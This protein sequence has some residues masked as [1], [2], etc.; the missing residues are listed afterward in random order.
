[1][2][3]VDKMDAVLLKLYDKS[4]EA[5][6]MAKLETWLSN[7]SIHKGEIE[8]ITL[9]LYR[10]EYMYSCDKSGDRNAEYHDEDMFLLSCEGKLFW[11]NEKGFRFYFA[12]LATEKAAREANELR[13]ALWTKR[14]TVAT[15]L[16]ATVIVGW[17]V[18][19]FGI[20]RGWEY[21]EYSVPIII[22]LSILCTLLLSLL[23]KKKKPKTT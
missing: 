11:E 21:R 12:K 8:D 13:L 19:K 5:P 23:L 2:E 7:E 17:D 4:G 15:Y 18:A 3:W 10:K 14:L 6:T 20:E 22:F 16:V 1:M 9:H